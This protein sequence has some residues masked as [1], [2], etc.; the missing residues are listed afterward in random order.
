M[1]ESASG[2]AEIIQHQIDS[3]QSWIGLGEEPIQSEY[4]T[5]EFK[6]RTFSH[7]KDSLFTLS[8]GMSSDIV[9]HHRSIYNALDLLGDIGGLLD[10][11][12]IIGQM[13]LICFTAVKGKPLSI[14]FVERL[15]K[16]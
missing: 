3:Q 10:M 7:F 14:F 5:V 12:L 9:V 15:F 1:N 4:Y 11:L 8:I 6:E 2:Q 13:V 16:R